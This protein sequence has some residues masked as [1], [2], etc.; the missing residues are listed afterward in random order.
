MEQVLILLPHPL[1]SAYQTVKVEGGV[2]KKLKVVVAWGEGEVKRFVVP[3]PKPRRG[4]RGSRLS[5]KAQGPTTRNR[6]GDAA[7]G[8]A[9][10]DEA[11]GA[12]LAQDETAGTESAQ[13]VSAVPAQDATA[14]MG[15]PEKKPST[16]AQA[17]HDRIS[18]YE[19]GASSQRGDK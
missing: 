15:H 4:G 5:R 8:G 3:I 18:R 1:F 14:G 10:S 11:V 19:R 9:P 17:W 2:N 16:K 12:V 13:A 7:Q 6:G